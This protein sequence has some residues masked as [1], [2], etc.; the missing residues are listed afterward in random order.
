MQEEVFWPGWAQF[1]QRW[2]LRAPAADFLE[3]AG[4]LRLLAAQ[5]VYLGQ[6][7]LRGALQSGEC[8]AL[9]RMLE[10]PKDWARFASFLRQEG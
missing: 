7:F 6:P 1:L 10:S 5:A 3:A 9:A 4:P 2:G 8:E